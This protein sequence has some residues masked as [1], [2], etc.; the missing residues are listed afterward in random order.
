MA[1]GYSFSSTTN[2]DNATLSYDKNGRLQIISVPPVDVNVNA[3]IINT[4]GAIGFNYG[5]AGTFTAT[6]TF[7]G[8]TTF[9]SVMSINN[10]D[11]RLIGTSTGYTTLNSGLSGGTNNIIT[12]PTTASDTLAALGTAQTFTATQSFNGGSSSE[13]GLTLP[14]FF[15]IAGGYIGGKGS[16]Q[17]WINTDT[18]GDIFI[19]TNQDIVISNINETSDA[20]F[21]VRGATQGVVTGNNT[22]DDGSGNVT[23]AGHLNLTTGTNKTVGQ[24]T[25][26]AGTV[27]VSNTSVTASSLI[28]LT[29]GGVGGT[30]GTLSVG[31]ITAGTSFV[32]N[33]SSS[34]DTSKVNWLIIN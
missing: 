23:F 4:G 3:P 24:S 28:F 5:Y 9:T 1:S 2:P 15:N 11:M 12:L 25:L 27:T 17:Q 34:T 31:T 32:I 16:N 20:Y 7:S 8:G 30:I 6:Q 22:L 21:A 18:T 14:G 13:A 33:S 10:G 19:Q 26:A 29:N